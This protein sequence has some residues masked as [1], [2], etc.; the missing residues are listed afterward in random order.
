MKAY[1]IIVAN[2]TLCG[3]TVSHLE[4]SLLLSFSWDERKDLIQE[5]FGIFE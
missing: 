2:G 3:V 4:H 5:K 1:Q